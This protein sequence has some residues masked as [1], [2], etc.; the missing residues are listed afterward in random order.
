MASGLDYAH[1]LGSV[2]RDV[3][4]ANVL[5]EKDESPVIADFGLVKLMQSTSLRS[6][7]GVTTG[8]PAYMSPEQVTGSKVGPPADRYSLATIAYE[9]LTGSIPFDGEGLM[10]VLYAQVHRD[11]PLPSA[12]NSSLS[13]QVDAVVMRGLAKDPAARWESCTAFV[14]ALA[15]SLAR[16]P[17]PGLALTLVMTPPVPSTVPP[18]APP[19]PPP[20]PL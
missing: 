18:A 7:T 5:L 4:P 17:D 12:R 1:S 13:Q 9:M 6:M 11:P 16:K 19:P 10:E 2:R 3:K 15:A 20:P 14:D 8:T